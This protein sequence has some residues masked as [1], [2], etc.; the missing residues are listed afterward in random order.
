MVA[1]ADVY[2]A[3]MEE[4]GRFANG[5]TL[6]YAAAKRALA[7]SDLP[8]PAGLDVEREVFVPLFAT[9]DQ[10]EGMRAFLDKRDPEFE[11]R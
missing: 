3:A 7:A 4:A 8:L 5:P 2:G 1:P 6:A 10:E 9:R 11:G